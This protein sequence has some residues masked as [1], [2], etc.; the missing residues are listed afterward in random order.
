MKSFYVYCL[1]FADNTYYIGYR[2]S[3]QPPSEDLLVKY[4]T[5]SKVVK[6][7]LKGAVPVVEILDSDLSKEDAYNKEQKLIYEH[8]SEAGCLNQ[9]CYYNRKGFGVLSQS[10]KEKIRTKSKERWADPAYKEKLSNIHKERWKNTE[11]KEK[12]RKRL[13]GVKRPGHSAKMT[14][15]II[16]EEQKEKMRRPKHPGHGKAVSKASTGVPKSKNHKTSLGISR[17]KNSGMFVDH[18][19]NTYLHHREFLEKYNLDKSFFDYLDKPI[20]Y[21]AVYD[22]LGIDYETNK[23]KTR[24]DLGFRFQE[25][26]I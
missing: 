25:I 2:G 10:A 12:Q 5:S 16:P 22:K 26:L 13:T 19:G 1:T 4:F 15:R 24:R 14:G 23:H 21:R 7:K 8:I 11:L 6:E 9:R 17:Q 18:L 3:C 20:R